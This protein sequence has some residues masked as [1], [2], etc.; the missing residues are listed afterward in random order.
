VKRA[1]IAE[2]RLAKAW[3]ARAFSR[4]P[5]ELPKERLLDCACELAKRPPLVLRY[6]R[7]LFTQDL[8]RAF[9][10]REA[11]ARRSPSRSAAE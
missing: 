3:R 6:T 2:L 7:M 9:H 10:A 11:Y 1:R 5:P 4:A 8:E